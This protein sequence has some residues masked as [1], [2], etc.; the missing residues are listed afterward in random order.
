M[1]LHLPSSSLADVTV[2][3]LDQVNMCIRGPVGTIVNIQTTS[4]YGAKTVT[5]ERRYVRRCAHNYSVP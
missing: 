2:M 1:I 5:L 4:E 3:S